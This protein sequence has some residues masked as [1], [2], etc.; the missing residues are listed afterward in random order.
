MG[1]SLSLPIVTSPWF[2]ISKCVDK[3]SRVDCPSVPSEELVALDDDNLFTAPIMVDK[4]ILEFDQSS[5]NIIDA[6]PNDENEINKT[7]LDPISSK[8]R[9]IEKSM[10]SY[11]D[12][13]SSGEMN[14][15]RD[16]IK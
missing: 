15:K 7:A 9:N 5:K 2:K 8:M 14:N 6:D 11:L 13:H 1:A 4:D 16:N 12:A 3:D 10:P